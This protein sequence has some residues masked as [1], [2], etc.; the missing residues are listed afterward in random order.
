[1][2]IPIFE[3]TLN[4]KAIPRASADLSSYDNPLWETFQINVVPTVIFFKDGRP[5]IRK[6]GTLGRG[7]SKKDLEELVNQISGHQVAPAGQ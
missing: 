4:A 3:S 2:F 1:M 7:L 5:L 6:D